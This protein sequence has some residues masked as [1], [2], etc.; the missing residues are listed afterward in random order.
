MRFRRVIVV[1]AGMVG[2]SCAW[3][4]QDY[5]AEV[6]VL[7]RGTAGAGS[8]W[9]NAGYLSPSLTVPL[10]EPSIL[11]YGLRAVLD[12]GSP[13]RL[14]IRADAK[15]ALFLLR[16]V[17]H[18]TNAHW[19]Q[20]MAGFR[21]LNAG[22]FAAF[23]A[24]RD[25]GVSVPVHDTAILAAFAGA[26]QATAFLHE[27]GGV[28]AAGQRVD[29]D[30]LTGDQARMAEPSLSARVAL[31]V[32]I[33]GQRYI[34]PVAY[35]SALADQVRTRGGKVTEGVTVRSVAGVGGRV[36]ISCQDGRRDADAVI[37]A[38]GAWMPALAA[39]HGVRVR[40][41]SGRGYS[42]AV[43]LARPLRGP[44]YFPGIRTALAPRGDQVRVTGMMEFARPDARMDA[45]AIASIVAAVRPLLDGAQWGRMSQQWVGSRP[46]TADAIPLVGPSATPG[47]YIAGGHGMWG[48]TLGPLTGR[49]LAE[50]M[51]TGITP[52]EL[53]WL[54]PLRR[55]RSQ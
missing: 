10:A 17:Q 40:Q 6:E 46:L 42:F 18:C 29:A 7:D 19:T 33:A 5:G 51:A 39:P 2:L 8:S 16:L 36:Q 9:G 53:A 11:R 54:D 55:S 35:T 38:A 47:V 26:K 20:A 31:A 3:A 1:G 21:M 49:L 28:A 22:I 32:R 44:L 45:A 52:P 15:L 13:V 48:V 30:L 37:L 14:P 34:D 24:Q 41:F 43:P 23:D 12:R 25:G 4:L 50:H 27:L